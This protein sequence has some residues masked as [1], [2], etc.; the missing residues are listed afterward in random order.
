MKA[1]SLKKKIETS[2]M[3]RR[4]FLRWSAL[5]GSSAA[6]SKNLAGGFRRLR[7]LL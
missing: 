6:A 5:V 4:S 2:G 1:P 7:N 3:S